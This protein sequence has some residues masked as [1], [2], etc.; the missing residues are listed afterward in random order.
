[1]LLFCSWLSI[2]ITTF[3][4]VNSVKKIV[5]GTKSIILITEIAF[6][7]VQIIPFILILIFN[8]QDDYRGYPNVYR[9]INDNTVRYIYCI[10]ILAIMLLLHYY[11]KK[12][13]RKHKVSFPFSNT[14]NI[15]VDFLIFLGMF[16][17]VLGVLLAPNPLNYFT[18]SFFQTHNISR[19]SMEYVY[20]NTIIRNLNYIAFFCAVY[21]Y[22]RKSSRRKYNN[23]IGCSIIIYS[24][25][26]G[27]RA[28]FCFSLIAILLIDWLKKEQGK[29]IKLLKKGFIFLF[30]IVIYFVFNGN[31]SGKSDINTDLINYELYFS[32]MSSVMTSIYDVINNW[33]ILD[34]HGQSLLYNIFFFIPRLIV[35]AKY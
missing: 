19:S 25:I 26:D 17:P 1:M 4:F 10:F 21:M 3:L 9:A 15:M 12:Y 34:Y 13:L 6:Y 35:S 7:I 8:F 23:L 32:R 29:N 20:H 24:W 33:E 27:K 22:F 5:R 18:Y 16:L 14:Q 11:E 28:L 2:F 30:I 31:I